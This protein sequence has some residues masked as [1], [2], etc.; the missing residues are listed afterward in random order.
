[1]IPLRDNV[2]SRTY[3]LVNTL[4]IWANFVVFAYEISRGALLE[5]FISRWGLVPARLA[6]EGFFSSAGLTILS[7]M[8]LHGGWLHILG[9][10]WFLYLFGD[11]V[12]DRLGHLRY[13]A[14]YLLCGTAGAVNHVLFNLGSTMPVVGASGAIAGVLGA[15]FVL[16]P[17]ARVATLVWGFLMA[18]V[19]E[20]PAMLFLG[21]WFLFQFLAGMASL[22][23]TM[24][25]SGGGIAWWAHVGGFVAGIVLVR[26]LCPARGP[27]RYP[28]DILPTR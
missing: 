5:E 15:Y 21:L 2:P 4:L 13:L 6:D 23:G 11:N 7:S 25:G 24:A 26:L 17:L 22:P 20:V 14:F 9:N 16:F 27:C 8:F 12:E 10:M 1:M 28:Y 18:W 3:P 19:V